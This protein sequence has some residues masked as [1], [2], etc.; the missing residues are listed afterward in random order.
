MNAL[1]LGEL[2]FELR[3]LF[4]YFFSIW[5]IP[6]A[7]NKGVT[8]C[9]VV[10]LCYVHVFHRNEGWGVEAILYSSIS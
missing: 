8:L 5:H 1:S 3:V 9:S 4:P 2:P 6:T 10:F 7:A